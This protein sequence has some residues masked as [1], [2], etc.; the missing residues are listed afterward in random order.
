MA[1]Q[2]RHTGGAAQ[3]LRPLLNF[4]TAAG[5]AK[6]TTNPVAL[7]R[8][9]ESVEALLSVVSAAIHVLLFTRRIVDDAG[10]V[11]GSHCEPGWEQG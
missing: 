5:Q 3:T 11:H 9:D 4:A 6:Q 8:R 10:S 1:L 7:V 2:T